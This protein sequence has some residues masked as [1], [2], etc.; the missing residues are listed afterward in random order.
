MAAATIRDLDASI[1]EKV[2]G[3]VLFGYTKNEQN[4]GQIPNYPSDRLLVFCNFGDLVCEGQ[5]II[6]APHLAYGD[7]ASGPAPEFL[8]SKI[9]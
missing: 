2:V 8:L 5:L 6:A 9:N 1:R 4:D 3:T 7:D